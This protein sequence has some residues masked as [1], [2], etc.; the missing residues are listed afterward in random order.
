MTDQFMADPILRE[1]YGLSAEDTFEG[2]FS[3]G[4]HGQVELAHDIRHHGSC[5]LC[6]GGNL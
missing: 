1:K 3:A 6:F 2:S 4:L 5:H